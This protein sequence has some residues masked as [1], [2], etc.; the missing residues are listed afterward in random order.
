MGKIQK[1]LAEYMKK[2]RTN[3]AAPADNVYDVIPQ[4]A[5]LYGTQVPEELTELLNT[6]NGGFIEIDENDCWRLL[7][8]SEM[9]TASIDLR[10]DFVGNGLIPIADC[11]ENNFICYDFAS[12]KQYLRFNIVDEMSFDTRAQLADFL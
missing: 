2:K 3:L 5:R 11:K 9:L 7:S 1:K 8:L 10:T 4:L 6:T 12:S